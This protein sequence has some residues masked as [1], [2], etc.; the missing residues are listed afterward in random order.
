MQMCICKKN[1]STIPACYLVSKSY[2]TLLTPWIV[3][4]KLL[5]PWDFLGKN[6]RVGC[7]FLLQEIF[8]TQGSNLC[9]LLGRHLLHWQAD[10]LP[11]SHQQVHMYLNKQI[12]IWNDTIFLVI[13]FRDVGL[14]LCELII[15]L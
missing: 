11:L 8:S 4:T 9:L 3:A 6:T 14:F 15:L 10:S 5:C 12:K 2:P 1:I 7:H 13:A